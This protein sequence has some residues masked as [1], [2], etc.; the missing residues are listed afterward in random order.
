MSAGTEWEQKIGRVRGWLAARDLDGLCFELSPG[1]AWLTGGLSN[2]RLLPEPYLDA[3][4]LVT[5]ER[6]VLLCTAAALRRLEACGGVAGEGGVREIDGSAPFAI[7]AA[8]AAIVAP[9]RL[10]VDSFAPPPIRAISMLEAAALRYPLLPE[11]VVRYRS[12][13]EHLGVAL[14][15][16]LL[17]CRPGMS[18]HQV[19]GLAAS[20]LVDFGCAWTQ[21]Y[22]A[23]DDRALSDP[24]A[25]STGRRIEHHVILTA[26]AQRHGLYAVA[27]RALHFGP[28]PDATRDAHRACI[29][30]VAERAGATRAGLAANEFRPRVGEPGSPVVVQGAPTGYA[31]YDPP[32]L[33]DMSLRYGMG[34][35]EMQY[36]LH[37]GQPAWWLASCPGAAYAD[38]VLEGEEGPEALTVTPDLPG[39]AALVLLER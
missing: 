1:F 2:A 8:A 32:E 31:V 17:H 39:S 10:A 36:N 22:A 24:L 35:P 19:A 28:A 30:A 12:L 29:A 6:V 20:V 21:V 34:P 27:I 9:S 38:T 33:P 26:T 4:L 3:G 14:T 25:P 18:E 13:G 37:P 11:E 16:A 23:A 15:H 5:R 7:T